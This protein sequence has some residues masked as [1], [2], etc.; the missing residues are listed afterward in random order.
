MTYAITFVD[1]AN[2]GKDRA[3]RGSPQAP[4][5]LVPSTCVCIE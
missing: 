2:I 4:R 3:L 1:P 5:P